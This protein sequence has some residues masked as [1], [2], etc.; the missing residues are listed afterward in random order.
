MLHPVAQLAQDA[1]GH[2]DRALGKRRTPTPLERTRRTTWWTLSS[3]TLGKSEN[4]K[5]A[6]TKKNT[7]FGLQQWIGHER[8]SMDA[9][10]AVQIAS[11]REPKLTGALKISP[12]PE[13]IFVDEH[14]GA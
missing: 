12:P 13:L 9:T 8:D 6:S 10:G 2:I 3:T 14:N 11:A 1:V 5:C 4:S 7:S